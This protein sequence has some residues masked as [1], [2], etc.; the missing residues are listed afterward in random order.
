MVGLCEQGWMT[1]RVAKCDMHQ[2][3]PDMA[4][5]MEME[6]V[7]NAGA[8]PDASSSVTCSQQ[9]LQVLSAALETS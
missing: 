2:R 3:L 7:Y 8:G 5:V 9:L 1:K 4:A 6:H